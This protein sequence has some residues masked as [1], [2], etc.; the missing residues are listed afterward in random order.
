MSIWFGGNPK[1]PPIRKH[2]DTYDSVQFTADEIKITC[3]NFDAKPFKVGQDYLYGLYYVKTNYAG[4]VVD[5]A[6]FQGMMYDA[7]YYAQVM[8]EMGYVGR[9]IKQFDGYWFEFN[10][11]YEKVLKERQRDRYGIAQ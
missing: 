11:E 1:G 8:K 3:F 4:K 10:K 2:P 6:I 7:I 9:F 5:N